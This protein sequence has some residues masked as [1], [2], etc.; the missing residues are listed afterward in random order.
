MINKKRIIF[1]LF[2][3]LVVMLFFTNVNYAFQTEIEYDGNKYISDIPEMYDEYE[4]YFILY[5]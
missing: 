2:L 5:F 3:I 1:I 4:Y